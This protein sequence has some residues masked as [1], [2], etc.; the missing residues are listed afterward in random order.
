M[1]GII[2]RDVRLLVPNATVAFVIGRIPMI[3]SFCA[4]E[5]SPLPTCPKNFLAVVL[6][7]L[8]V[9][10]VPTTVVFTVSIG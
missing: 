8:S 5:L 1:K 2:G 7:F 9:V 4:F 6:A 3:A 10:L